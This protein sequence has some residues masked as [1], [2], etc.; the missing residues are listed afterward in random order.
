MLSRLDSPSKQ[1]FSLLMVTGITMLAIS[2]GGFFFSPN[3]HLLEFHRQWA[4]SDPGAGGK[5]NYY[6][7]DST[8]AAPLASAEVDR[9]R[10]NPAFPG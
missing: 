5:K 9:A 3:R 8:C 4:Y 10:V 7:I 6:T 1:V 2:I